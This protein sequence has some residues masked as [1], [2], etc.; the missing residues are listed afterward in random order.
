MGQELEEK[1]KLY[2]R[3][4]KAGSQHSSYEIFSEDP[5]LSFLYKKTERVTA[6]LYLV[7]NLLPTSEPLRIRL[8]ECGL[9]IL[10]EALSFM[11]AQLP[12]AQVW[13]QRISMAATEMEAL[14]TVARIAGA[15]S[16]MNTSLLSRE[17]DTVAKISQEYADSRAVPLG[18]IRLSEDFFASNTPTPIE[19]TPPAALSKPTPSALPP[20][21]FPKNISADVTMPPAASRGVPVERAASRVE[22]QSGKVADKKLDR[23]DRIIILLKKQPRISIKDAAEAIPDC[24]EKTLQRELLTLVEEGVVVKIGER[25]WS[26]YTLAQA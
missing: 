26:T 10:S 18:Q 24:S 22:R 14:L 3:Q 1:D 12:S 8:R 6:A 7:T 11:D 20:R 21:V 19:H 13:A 16:E 9:A 23:R 15:V 17:Y 25:R 4:E 5:K 2:K